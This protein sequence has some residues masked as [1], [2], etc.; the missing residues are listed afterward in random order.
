MEW[1][2]CAVYKKVWFVGLNLQYHYFNV[3]RK[4]P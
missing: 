1:K 3:F 4:N 2:A